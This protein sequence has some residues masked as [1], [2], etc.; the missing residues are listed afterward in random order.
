M[1]FTPP[2]N[3][4]PPSTPDPS[5]QELTFELIRAILYFAGTVGVVLPAT[6]SAPAVEWQVAGGLVLLG[7]T[8]WALVQKKIDARKAHESI[9]ASLKLNRAVRVA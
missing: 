4:L 1:S 3:P 2:P 7:T 5:V 6:A 9:V 8:A